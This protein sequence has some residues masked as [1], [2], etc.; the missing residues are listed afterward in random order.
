MAFASLSPQS[1]RVPGRRLNPRS[2]RGF[3][4]IELLVVCAIVVIISSLI[5]VDNNK[6]GG[7]V[8]LENLAYDIALTI[9][10]AQVYGIA[11][12]NVGNNS[13]FSSGYGVVFSANYASLNPPQYYL[14]ADL[15]NN[16]IYNPSYTPSEEVQEE[17]LQQGY[18][19]SQLCVISESN[20][21]L[22]TPSE[23]D[24]LFKRPEP[25][26]YISAGF[27]G[28]TPA[29]CSIGFAQNN[30]TNCY[31]EAEI[32][33]E[34]PKGGTRTVDVYQN[35]QISVQQTTSDF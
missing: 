14:F 22:C 20:T 24:I 29:S 12:A 8:T 26:A 21:T 27:N 10:Q 32:T 19:V 33:I 7:E 5:L 23:V 6:F 35:G 28:A 18:Q 3:T 16:G 11:V 2:S 25:V 1:D 9:R 13:N 31:T 17:D 4:L 30:F 34:S 15:Q